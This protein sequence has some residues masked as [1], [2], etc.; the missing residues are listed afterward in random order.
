[1]LIVRRLARTVVVLLLVSIMTFLALRLTPGDPALLLM[2]PQAGRAD[3]YQRYLDLRAEMGLDES[4]PVQYRIW[5]GKVLRGDLGES[6]RSGE[7]VIEAVLEKLP[8]TLA[9]ATGA[10]LISVPTSIIIG[11]LAARRGSMTRDRTVRAVTTLF[12]AVPGFWVGILLIILM[13]V[14]LG[15]LPPSGYRPLSAGLWP[16]MRHLLMPS[17]SLGLLLIGIMTRFVYTEM[18]DV[19]ASDYVRN[20]RALGVSENAI[21]FRHAARNALLPLVS[22]VGLQVGTLIGGAVLI[23]Q[24]FGIAGVGQLMLQGV[25]F[26]DYQVV[27]GAV[28]LITVGILMFNYV[29]DMLYRVVDPRIRIG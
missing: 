2:G 23:E 6:N 14:R 19:L 25:L 26:R 8:A 7:P 22:V 29:T 10:L 4:L 18:R 15:L 13:S 24:V 16:F 17:L 9:L 28:L 12:L 5:G 21:L 20:L 11:V 3:N 1:M 27:Q